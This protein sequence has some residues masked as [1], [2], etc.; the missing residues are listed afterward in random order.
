MFMIT[1]LIQSAQK[2]PAMLVI[3]RLWTGSPDTNVNVQP[4]TMATIATNITLVYLNHVELSEHA[5]ISVK[6][7][8]CIHTKMA[9]TDETVVFLSPAI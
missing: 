5:R 3:A 2:N 7:I 1:S 9:F 6:P 8:I 4:V